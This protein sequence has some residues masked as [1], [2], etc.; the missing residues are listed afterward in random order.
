ML[1]TFLCEQDEVNEHHIMLGAALFIYP[2]SRFIFTSHFGGS[3]SKY[4]IGVEPKTDI[5]SYFLS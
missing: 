5:S 1:A 4:I 2:V 3:P